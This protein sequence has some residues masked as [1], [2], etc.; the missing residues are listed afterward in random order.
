MC[1][2]LEL[3]VTQNSRA[4]KASRVAACHTCAPCTIKSVQRTPCATT[5]TQIV[6]LNNQKLAR[7]RV[8]VE[9]VS[10]STTLA[11]AQARWRAA[12]ARPDYFWRFEYAYH[13]NNFAT[14][15]EALEE[16]RSVV[17]EGQARTL[18]VLETYAGAG[19]TS[20]LAH[21]GSKVHLESTWSVDLFD[22]AMLTY[23]V[24][25]PGCHVR[26]SS[27]GYVAVASEW[28]VHDDAL[29]APRVLVVCW[30]HVCS[31][32]SIIDLMPPACA[33]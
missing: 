17:P 26:S 9:F 24:N 25:H 33:C 18:H 4:R 22:D 20:F 28:L 27:S 14:P 7:R 1:M 21:R 2:S 29:Q 16:V 13:Y 11:A 31:N 19:G 8:T 6:H 23:A 3:A 30:Q 5:T 10:P 15:R 12:G 32:A